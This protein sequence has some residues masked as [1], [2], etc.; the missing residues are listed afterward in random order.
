MTILESAFEQVSEDIDAGR[1]KIYEYDLRVEVPLKEGV[2]SVRG[3]P[4]L[5]K[6]MEIIKSA[7]RNEEIVEFCDTENNQVSPDLT[8][9]KAEKIGQLFC[10]ETT[11]GR[12]KTLIFGFKFKTTIPFSAIKERTFSKLTEENVFIRIH[13][14]GYKHG[15]NWTNLGFMIGQHPFTS[16]KNDI[17]KTILN[18][19]Q[20]G[21]MKDK[22]FWTTAKKKELKTSIAP[23]DSNFSL[24]KIPLV[25]APA[26]ISS[27]QEGGTIRTNVTMITTPHKY[28]AAV[29]QIL[30]YM[31]LN[32]KNIEGY[33]PLQYKHDNPASF[34]NI[35]TQQSDWME[36]HRNIQV[37]YGDG[38]KTS[39][40]HGKDGINIEQLLKQQP[41]VIAVHID[42]ALRRFNISVTKKDYRKTI[43]TL[44]V[45]IENQNFPFEL[46]VKMPKATTISGTTISDT[47]TATKYQQAL[48]NI[49]TAANKNSITRAKSE[50]TPLT[51][52]WRRRSQI[53]ITID[54]MNETD[55]FPPLPSQPRNPDRSQGSEPSNTSITT[56]TL[57]TAVAEAVAQTQK[58]HN[59]EM[60]VLRSEIK[61]MKE[62]F[63][64]MM[65]TI[66]HQSDIIN[67]HIRILKENK[68]DASP[69]R[70][71]RPTQTATTPIKH[72]KNSATHHM[73]VELEKNESN[74]QIDTEEINMR[75][76]DSD[77][78]ED[79]PDS[80]TDN[81]PSTHTDASASGGRE[82]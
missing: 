2:E 57:Q 66:S 69:P 75:N 47:T 71:K 5:I 8:G 32:A 20:A 15:V 50:T 78:D 60:Q 12:K 46:S 38:Y 77:N 6:A 64:V 19:A 11:K 51:N 36:D 48:A 52:V 37:N 21:W 40:Q 56:T 1:I 26:P 49:V 80:E 76:W 68:A 25:A 33:V 79:E 18:N 44:Q 67:Q 22:T 28:A 24:L 55:I 61:N 63:E 58:S 3:K 54:F 74:L 35:V 30:D 62:T 39:S 7:Q 73:E 29:T 31:L 13:H 34:H 14:G 27:K 59:K 70:K 45:E 10:A 81:V 53:P 4:I 42:E 16:N 9:L 23:D 82:D 43:K 65:K 41:G 17:V 72:T